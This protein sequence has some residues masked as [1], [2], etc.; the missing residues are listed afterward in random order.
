MGASV[1]VPRPGRTKVGEWLSSSVRREAANLT[2]EHFGRARKVYVHPHLTEGR[3][4]VERCAGRSLA[5]VAQLWMGAWQ[6]G[7]GPAGAD[8]MLRW[9]KDFRDFLWDKP[10]EATA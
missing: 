1:A 6:A 4:S 3:I 5:G 7:E 10:G 9:L 2:R 8:A